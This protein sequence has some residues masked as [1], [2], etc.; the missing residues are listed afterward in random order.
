MQTKTITVD[1]TALL[2]RVRLAVAYLADRHPTLQD[3]Y[4]E[5]LMTTG[6]SE[7]ATLYCETALDWVASA[8][9]RF[10]ATWN[11]TTGTG[12]PHYSLTLGLSDHSLAAQTSVID[13]LIS[14]AVENKIVADW[15]QTVSSAEQEVYKQRPLGFLE[16]A[17]NL[18]NR[19]V[20]PTVN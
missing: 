10:K 6:D 14:R 2:G 13:S 12:A 19:R 16:E 17:L 7:L 15:I 4:K 18:C 3:H 5:V 11:K 8:L 9:H 1:Q 20:R